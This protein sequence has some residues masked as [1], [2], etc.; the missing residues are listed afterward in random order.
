MPNPTCYVDGK[1]IRGKYALVEVG[2]ESVLKPVCL[3]HR[4]SPIAVPMGDT[5]LSQK[6]IEALMEK[7]AQRDRVGAKGFKR[8]SWAYD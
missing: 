1:T 7:E 6:G 3:A 2:S 8:P 4:Y 5:L